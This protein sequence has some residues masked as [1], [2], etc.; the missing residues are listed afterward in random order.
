MKKNVFIFLLLAQIVLAQENLS[1]IKY[2]D[3]LGHPTTKETFF[4]YQTFKKENPEEEKYVLQTFNKQDHLV[5]SYTYSDA[6][7]KLISG[8][9][10]E[11]DGTKNEYTALEVKPEPKKG[12][13]DF[14]KFISNHFTPTDLAYKNKVKGK[15]MLEFIVDKTG[16]ITDIKVIKGLGYGLDQEAIRVLS[17]YEDWYPALQKGRHVRCRYTIPISLDFSY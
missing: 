12:L 17:I 16:K 10:T 7:G 8:V 1:A 9:S 6:E 3:S 5:T 2:L 15:I 4:R 13:K 14:Y 11:S